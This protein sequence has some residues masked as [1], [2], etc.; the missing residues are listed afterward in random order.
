[1]K[2]EIKFRGYDNVGS[3][4]YSENDLFHFFKWA[5]YDSNTIIEQFSELKDKNGVEIYEGDIVKYIHYNTKIVDIVKFT[6]CR[7]RPVS[8]FNTSG[9]FEVIG[10]IHQNKDLL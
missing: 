6:N 9:E 3:F 10:N 1:M 4:E 8:N 7:F 5:S 2:R